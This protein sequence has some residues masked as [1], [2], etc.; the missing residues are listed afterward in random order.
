MSMPRDAKARTAGWRDV[1]AALEGRASK[2]SIYIGRK[3]RA[4]AAENR[5]RRAVVAWRTPSK[6]WN[7]NERNPTIGRTPT[8]AD[9]TG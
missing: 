9:A 8:E 5:S 7:G 1:P 6:S 2:P 4:R 3:V